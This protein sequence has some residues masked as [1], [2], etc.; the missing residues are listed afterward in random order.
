MTSEDLKG[1]IYLLDFWASWCSPCVEKFPRLQEIDK[2]CDG[3]VKVIAVNVDT[4]ENAARAEKIVQQYNLTWDHVMS[5][6]GDSDPLWRN[7]RQHGRDPY[8]NS[9]VRARGQPGSDSVCE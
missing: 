2:E 8:G 3:R 4:E 7:V 6:M 5:K 9:P 1:E